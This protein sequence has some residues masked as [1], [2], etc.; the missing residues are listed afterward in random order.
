[1]QAPQRIKIRFGT[2]QSTPLNLD[3][4]I[5]VFHRW[6][7][8][9]KTPSTMVD[10]ADYKH[11]PAGPGVMLVGHSDDLGLD[12]GRRAG[13]EANGFY[14]VRKHSRLS[15]AQPLSKRLQEIWALTIT[16]GMLLEAESNLNVA[17][18][19]SAVE[20]FLMDR[21]L[22]PRAAPNLHEA[23]C[24]IRSGLSRVLGEFD[25]PM[26]RSDVDEREPVS[27]LVKLPKGKSLASMGVPLAS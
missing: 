9:E 4:L 22:Y 24:E 14:Y 13:E 19:T 5:P 17:I 7:Q 12:T 6:I 1:M 11:V 27:W 25:F 21:L 2:A 16:T 18:E 26:E 20:V 23:E 15:D 8:E 10:V 3:N